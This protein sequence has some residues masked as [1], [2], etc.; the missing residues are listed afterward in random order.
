VDKSLVTGEQGKKGGEIG[1][2]WDDK[3]SNNQRKVQKQK[4]VAGNV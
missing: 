3:F 4:L 1:K 2:N